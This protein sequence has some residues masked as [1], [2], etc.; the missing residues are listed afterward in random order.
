MR[1][2]RTM[3]SETVAGDVHVVLEAS[4]LQLLDECGLL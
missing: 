2:G 1:T 4:L 3:M